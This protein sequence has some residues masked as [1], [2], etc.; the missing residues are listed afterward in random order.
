VFVVPSDP[1]KRTRASAKL[2]TFSSDS[3]PGT[4]CNRLS[5][6]D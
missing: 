6:D 5:G 1:F 2:K 3:G 4:V